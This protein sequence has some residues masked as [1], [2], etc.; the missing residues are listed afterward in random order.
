MTI[1]TS[2]YVK[3]KSGSLPI[4]LTINIIHDT[5]EIELLLNEIPNIQ[6]ET[7]TGT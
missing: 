1:D 5:I 6:V 2:L 7:Y 3:A 4:P